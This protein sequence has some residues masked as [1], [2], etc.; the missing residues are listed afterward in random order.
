LT[1]LARRS[2]Q[3]WPGHSDLE[4]AFASSDGALALLQ[5]RPVTS[6]PAAA[7]RAR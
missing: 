5:R 1:A 3:V 4:Y 7:A 2:R 6:W